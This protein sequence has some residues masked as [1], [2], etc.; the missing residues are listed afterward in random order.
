MNY[1]VV[2]T[3]KDFYRRKIED[4]R[5]SI[6][7][8]KVRNEMKDK[9]NADYVEASEYCDAIS[10]YVNTLDTLNSRLIKEND[11]FR[12]RRLDHLNSVITE[13]IAEIFPEKRLKARVICDFKRSSTV[14]LELTDANGEVFAPQICNG[15][16]LQYLTS[17]SAI[18]GIANS[19]G[20]HNLFIDEAFG[21]ASQDNLSKIGDIIN[22]K[23]ENGLQ[24]ILVSQNPTLYMD[25]PHRELI[26]EADAPMHAKLVSIEDFGDLSNSNDLGGVADE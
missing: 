3:N 13:G 9:L 4:I 18:C 11:E 19:L 26:L 24:V 8:A 25:I 5:I 6:E 21:V 1:S 20:C 2:K 7:T 16:L 22:K 17:F 14:R 10:K 23:I 12:T 15:K